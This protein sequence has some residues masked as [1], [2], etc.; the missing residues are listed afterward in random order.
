MRHIIRKYQRIACSAAI[1]S[2]FTVMHVAIG[3]GPEAPPPGAM[4]IPG[5]LGP[6][7]MNVDKELAKMA[8]RYGLTETQKIQ[9]RPILVEE[10]QR[11]EDLF[12]DSSHPP[13]DV[14][15]AMRNI[16]REETSRVS[17]ILTDRQCEKYRRDQEQV[18]RQPGADGAEPPLPTPDGQGS[19]PPPES[20]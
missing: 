1:I 9:I 11:M 19:P 18:E 8:K 3:Q 7:S 4:G 16:R 6:P 13:E 12:K 5:A 17:L 15:S 20:L 14:F 2:L 10:K